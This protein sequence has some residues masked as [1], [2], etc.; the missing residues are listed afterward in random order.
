MKCMADEINVT[1]FLN[2]YYSLLDEYR[3]KIDKIEA[4]NRK[5]L[6]FKINEY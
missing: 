2:E 5:L 1:D 6:L 3:D 4:E